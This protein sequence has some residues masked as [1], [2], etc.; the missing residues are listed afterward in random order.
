MY[1]TK[2]TCNKISGNLPLINIISGFWVK[3]SMSGYG[4]YIFTATGPGGSTQ[5]VISVNQTNF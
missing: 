4:T 2:L 1:A 3:D 5:S